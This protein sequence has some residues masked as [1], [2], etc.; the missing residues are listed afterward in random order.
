MASLSLRAYAPGLLGFILVKVLAPGYFARQDTRTPVRIGVQALSLS[1][2]LNV[3][4]VVVLVRTAWAPAHVGI[5]AATSC[6]ALFNSAGL[7]FGLLRSGVY[8][9][10]SGWRELFALVVGAN[11]VMSGALYMALERFGDWLAHG[12]ARTHHGF[13]A[14]VCGAALVYFAVCYLFGLRVGDLRMRPSA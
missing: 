11:I 7:L 6:S 12:V 4:F 9:P 2:A 8:R 5:A 10:R 1:M 13:A 14:L 3:M